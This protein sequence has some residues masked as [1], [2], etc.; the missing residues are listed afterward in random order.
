[1]TEK[2]LPTFELAQHLRLIAEKLPEHR[3]IINEAVQRLCEG[4]LRERKIR[5]ALDGD[6]YARID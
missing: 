4:A 2:G 6:P 5:A 1:M 3:F